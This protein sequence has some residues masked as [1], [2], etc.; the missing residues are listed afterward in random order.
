MCVA[1]C[2]C[3]LVE[4][5]FFKYLLRHVILVYNENEIIIVFIII[6]IKKNWKRKT[7]DNIDVYNILLC[8]C[9]FAVQWDWSCL[10]SA[11]ECPFFCRRSFICYAFKDAPNSLRF[12]KILYCSNISFGLLLFFWYKY[13]IFGIFWVCKSFFFFDSFCVNFYYFK[14]FFV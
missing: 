9:L 4:I 2:A 3:A 7:K 11:F 14:D 1:Q 10:V 13:F 6:A 8:V 12:Y 5:R